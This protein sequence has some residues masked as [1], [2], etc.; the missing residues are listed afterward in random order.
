MKLQ[1]F[2]IRCLNLFLLSCLIAI[3]AIAVF[4]Y[5]TPISADIPAPLPRKK[6][7]LP[8]S[9]APENENP[10]QDTISSPF[11]QL[12]QKSLTPRLPDLKTTLGYYGSNHRPDISQAGSLVQIGIRGEPIPASIAPQTPLYLRH[13]Y[14]HN[15]VRWLF[16]PNN[17]PTNI[18]IEVHPLGT[19]EAKI[20]V[21]MKD[22]EGNLIT[23]PQEC[24]SFLLAQG[25]LP[26]APQTAYAW[27]IEGTRVDASLLS[28]QKAQWCG[29]DIFLELLGQE[30][31][32]ELIGKERIS[33]TQPDGS[34][35][36]LFVSK[37]SSFVF[38]DGQWHP[39]E[40][41]EA[42]RNKP[43]LIIQDIDERAIHTEIW[44]P[45]GK[46]KIA[47]QLHKA[48]VGKF[49]TDKLDIKLVG[50]RSR[51]DWI[52]EVGG[53]RMLLRDDDWLLYTNGE[54]I[55]INDVQTLD[56]FIKGS[57]KGVLVVLEGVD[58]TCN[59]S[60]LL[61]RV[62]DETRTQE[63]PLQITLFKSWDGKKKK[64]SSDADED[65]TDEFDEEDDD[66]EDLS[67]PDDDDEEYDVDIDDDDDDG[68]I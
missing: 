12:Q 44:D 24:A 1:P 8:F 35:Y 53:S 59:D 58:K 7:S 15:S 3:S 46:H 62:F 56:R 32:P 52:A 38:V 57:L 11:L 14:K 42:S 60:T 47:L 5:S 25:R 54:W 66:D 37:G 22:A 68:V 55:K 23:E 48:P 29:K 33:F 64:R 49:S 6:A 26:S 40:L 63:L 4:Q 67:S 18:W 20:A 27:D 45:S 21:F 51:K 31:Y 28:K 2:A 30:E 19:K 10:A 16:S 41:G 61:A 9:F 36:S 50:A 65:E 34:V 17:A 43:L 39:V 13:E